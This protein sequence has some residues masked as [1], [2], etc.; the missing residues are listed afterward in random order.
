[1]LLSWID[2]DGCFVFSGLNSLLEY[3]CQGF[4]GYLCVLCQK[5]L[6]AVQIISHCIS[7]DHVYWYL[8]SAY[9]CKLILMGFYLQQLLVTLAICVPESFY[10]SDVIHSFLLFYF[11]LGSCSPRNFGPSQKQLQSLPPHSQQEDS[12]F[13]QSGPDSLPSS[14]NRGNAIF[15][16]NIKLL[17]QNC[18]G[19][20]L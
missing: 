11:F 3:S 18:F 9:R 8:V 14:G 20:K 6:P 15:N 7:F 2:V 4:C 1:M 10:S 13:G 12:L 17:G 5:K 19:S 16:L